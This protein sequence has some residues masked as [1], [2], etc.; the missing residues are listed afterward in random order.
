[1]AA[2]RALIGLLVASILASIVLASPAVE[3]DLDEVI[4]EMVEAHE[5]IQAPPA[6]FAAAA[7]KSKK[8]PKARKVVLPKVPKAKVPKKRSP[9]KKVATKKK[10]AKK[11]LKDLPPPHKI[12]MTCIQR[13]QVSLSTL[14]NYNAA[15]TLRDASLEFSVEDTASKWR[16]N[17]WHKRYVRAAAEYAFFCEQS[18]SAVSKITATVRRQEAIESQK[19]ALKG[20]QQA[21]QARQERLVKYHSERRRKKAEDD[22]RAKEEKQKKLIQE[23]AQKARL[24]RLRSYPQDSLDFEGFVA[25]AETGQG[26]GSA[27]IEVKCPFKT[28]KGRSGEGGKK[29]FA[30]Y[31][32]RHAITGPDGYRCYATFSKRGYIPLKY[33]LVIGKH[34][35]PALFRTAMLLPQRS[36]SHVPF[37]VVLQ[38]GNQP[39]DIDAH[40]FIMKAS[41][42]THKPVNVGEH[43][44]GSASFSYEPKGSASSFPFMTLD[45]KCNA[46]YGPETHSIHKTLPVKY[47]FYVK[48][49]DHHITNNAIFHN[50]EARVF[51]YQGTKLTHSFAIRNAQGTPSSY[52]QVFSIDCTANKGAAGC[53]V[54]PIDAFVTE[55]PVSPILATKH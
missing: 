31:L 27:L 21:T 41:P 49:Y 4:P 20:L 1:M 10:S 7:K 30:K 25:D 40:L 53:K 12:A 26:V 24:V 52:W 34:D 33:D 3:D 55:Q 15:K 54:L 50:S 29:T 16:I 36:S 44:D 9:S 23:T 6:S 46:G 32:I 42:T 35:T 19:A 18:Q 51:L 48:N 22:T 45:A 43:F 17:E 28:Y 8:V 13:K 11:T 2:A 14:M 39:A 37:R 38:Y 47:G 5:L